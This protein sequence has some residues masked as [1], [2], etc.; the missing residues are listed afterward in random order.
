MDES[1]RGRE[2]GE[3]SQRGMEESQ[4]GKVREG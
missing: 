1:E 4:R 2:R 3:E